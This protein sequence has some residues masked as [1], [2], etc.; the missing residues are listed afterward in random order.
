MRA[1]YQALDSPIPASA[2]EQQSTADSIRHSDVESV[3]E[4]LHSPASTRSRTQSS[5]AMISPYDR[6]HKYTYS[7]VVSPRLGAAAPEIWWT[8][9]DRKARHSP[10]PRATQAETRVS[11]MRF[12][13]PPKGGSRGASPTKSRS[14]S[15]SPVHQTFDK[16]FQKPWLQ[17]LN[18]TV[19][20]SRDVHKQKIEKE[21]ARSA[22]LQ[23]LDDRYRQKWEE[24]KRKS[25]TSSSPN[26]ATSPM[27]AVEDPSQDQSS[28]QY[29]S[30]VAF[31]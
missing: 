8:D 16:H 7:S 11:H 5:P 29:G 30:R 21:Q 9:G 6:F 17:G 2:G 15:E 1:S 22:A 3:D 10:S 23:K 20:K 18:S 12:R 19:A 4:S 14:D 28:P 13:S 27:P 25:A 26:S 31:T 24:F